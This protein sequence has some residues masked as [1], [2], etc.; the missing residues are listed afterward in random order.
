MAE[1]LK[2]IPGS[3]RAENR[4][5]TKREITF[6]IPQTFNDLRL[7]EVEDLFCLPRYSKYPPFAFAIS[8]PLCQSKPLNL[9][10][11]NP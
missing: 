10:L 7:L 8:K 2:P 5:L 6:A 1:A 4:L 9:E 3:V 11:S